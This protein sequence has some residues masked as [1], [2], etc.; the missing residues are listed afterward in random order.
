MISRLRFD[1]A[2]GLLF[3]FPP[4]NSLVFG[5][6]FLVHFSLSLGIC[7]LRFAHGFSFAM[8][9]DF[10]LA[11]P[12]G[13]RTPT[14]RRRDGWANHRR[15]PP[16]CAKDVSSGDAHRSPDFNTTTS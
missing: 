9:C 14:Q 3:S 10:L 4:A 5:L 2:G 13:F 6:S 1:G 7:V 12:P 15:N 8:A 11:S 16:R